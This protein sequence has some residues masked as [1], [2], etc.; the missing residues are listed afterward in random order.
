MT[1]RWYI[2]YDIYLEIPPPMYIYIYVLLFYDI[3]ILSINDNN[4]DDIINYDNVYDNINNDYYY[5]LCLRKRK[6]NTNKEQQ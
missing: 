2:I 3:C 4:D 5:V 1:Y 6:D